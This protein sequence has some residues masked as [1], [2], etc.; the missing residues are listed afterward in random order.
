MN[1]KFSLLAAAISLALSAPAIA[2]SS[3]AT[4]RKLPAATLPP[5]PVASLNKAPVI[6]DPPPV[7]VELPPMTAEQIVD[8]NVAARGG[9]AGWRK[10]QTMM[11]SGKMD[12]GKR[13][14][15]GGQFAKVQDAKARA[16]AKA[17]ARMVALG[18]AEPPPDNTIRL[19]FQMELQRP[20]KSRLEVEVKGEKALQVFDGSQ[21]WKLR[22]YLGRHEVEAFNADE[23]KVAELQQP[24]DGP[25]IDYRAKGS[26]LAVLGGEMV[27]GRGAYKLEVTLKNGDIRHVWVDA[28]TFLDVKIDG[29]PKRVDGR[30]RTVSTFI[31]DYRQ[32]DGLMVPYLLETRVEG[33][34]D[35]ARIVVEHVA[36]NPPLD[37]ARFAKP[38]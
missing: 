5:P 14:V 28:Q 30:L 31:R 2:A 22:P 21:G 24:L 18:K 10:V 19:P 13:R 27:D 11:L 38:E 25:L 7:V 1:L 36:L 29:A 33:L 15:D 12:A 34:R 35:P 32:V 8:R 20:L 26:K 16:E 6:K 4:E 17:L 9:L 23:L 37:N 3:I